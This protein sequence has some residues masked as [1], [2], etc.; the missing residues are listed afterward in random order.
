MISQELQHASGTALT[1]EADDSFQAARWL[2]YFQDN[3]SARGKITIPSGIAVSKTL[4]LPLIR[5]LQ[6]FQIG[7]TGEGMH[8]KRYASKTGDQVY[9][10]CIDLFIKE[11]QFHSRVLA[12]MIAAVDGT[13]LSWHWSDLAFICLRRMLGLKTEI[14]IILVA[15]IIGKCFYRLCADKLQNETLSDAFSLIVLDEIGHLEFHCA[16]LRT[17]MRKA[18]TAVRYCVYWGW[19]TIFYAG[20]IVFIADH[21]KTLKALGG[22]PRDFL[23]Q[24]SRTFHRAAA[25]ALTVCSD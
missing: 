13:L 23:Q 25:R 10:Q 12:D 14:F 1:D 7:E 11:E 5:S 21:Q 16:F 8:L 15:E 22:S 4:R 18:S 3:K 6:R 17:Q 24:C 2:Q 20:C 19:A 9:E